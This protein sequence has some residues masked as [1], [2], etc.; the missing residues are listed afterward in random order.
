MHLPIRINPKIFRAQNFKQTAMKKVI[1][2]AVLIAESLGSFSAH[3]QHFEKGLLAYDEFTRAKTITN[4]IPKSPK[5]KAVPIP[6]LAGNDFMPKNNY[7]VNSHCVRDIYRGTEAELNHFIEKLIPAKKGRKDYNP[8]YNKGESFIRIGKK[9][10]INPSVLA[11]ISMIES[12]R[13][14]SVLALKKNNVGGLNTKRKFKDVEECI[15]KMAE[16]LDKRYKEGTRT[17]KEIGLS[18][19]YCAKEAGE[20]WAKNVVFF[21]NRM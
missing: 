9:Y 7:S 8:L 14:T 5:P 11:A 20:H 17:V 21:L 18:G 3:A 16:I 19:K 15:E 13:G 12:S 2:S 6:P 4:F 10:N 1:P